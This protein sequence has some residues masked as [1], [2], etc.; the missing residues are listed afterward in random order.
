[1]I[2]KTKIIIPSR[3]GASRQKTVE[4][5]PVE[6]HKHILVVSSE[7][8]NL[9][10]EVNQLVVG[11][12]GISKKRQL[13]HQMQIDIGEDYF[14]VDD[15]VIFRAYYD[16]KSKI[17]KATLSS[18]ERFESICIENREKYGLI[19]THPRAF[20][21]V[22]EA[23]RNGISK[24]VYHNV[25]KTRNARYDKGEQFEDIE[26]YLQLIEQKVL[27]VKHN[28]LVTVYDFSEHSD[29]YESRGKTIQR[30]SR[31]YPNA[32]TVRDGPSE[33][34]GGKKVPYT[35]RI[36]W[37]YAKKPKTTMIELENA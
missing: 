25:E 34:A 6:L 26:F 27:C 23:F 9:P 7:F 18:F 13:I 29:S 35:F 31:E 19:S 12:I 37:S 33:I 17:Q 32:I 5:I 14:M 8:A 20:S 30:W 1:M 28:S 24:L 22:P 11:N 10:Q 15:D 21:H 2:F 4:S 36:N 3:G 16:E